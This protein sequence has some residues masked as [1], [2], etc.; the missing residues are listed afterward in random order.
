MWLCLLIAIFLV[1]PATSFV[2]SRFCPRSVFVFSLVLMGIGLGMFAF[3]FIASE[4]GFGNRFLDGMPTLQS[5]FNPIL[6]VMTGLA[7]LFFG[8]SICIGFAIR[9]LTEKA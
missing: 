6:L 5:Y 2:V 3:L 8:M 1:V 9:K 4:I 7:C